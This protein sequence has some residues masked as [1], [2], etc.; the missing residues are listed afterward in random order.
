MQRP[1]KTDKTGFP[2]SHETRQ[3]SP[4]GKRRCTAQPPKAAHLLKRV[5]GNLFECLA[6]AKS[7]QYKFSYDFCNYC[8]W[9]LKDNAIMPDPETPCLNQVINS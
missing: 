8:S 3:T 4:P 7:C 9:L 5:S 2:P 6:D 1:A